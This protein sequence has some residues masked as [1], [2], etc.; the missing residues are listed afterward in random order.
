MQRAHTLQKVRRSLTKKHVGYKQNNMLKIEQT[1]AN[2]YKIQVKARLPRCITSGRRCIGGV[3]SKPKGGGTVRRPVLTTGRR[4]RASA[5]VA[6]MERWLHHMVLSR[7]WMRRKQANVRKAAV[8]GDAVF[9]NLRGGG[10][11]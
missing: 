2:D 6:G 9:I 11:P 5:E 3:G 1:A 7:G 4:I 10:L 8:A